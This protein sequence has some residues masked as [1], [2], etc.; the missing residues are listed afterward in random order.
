MTAPSDRP[1]ISM[2]LPPLD[3]APAAWLLDLCCQLQSILWRTYGAELE[4]HWTATEPGQLIYGPL[5]KPRRR[6]R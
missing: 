3:I 1:A 6:R 4:A 2:P 5:P